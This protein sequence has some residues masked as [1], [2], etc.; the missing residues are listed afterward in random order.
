MAATADSNAQ[1]EPVS[2]WRGTIRRVLWDAIWLWLAL[3]VSSSV[4]VLKY[5]GWPGVVAYSIITAG[6]VTLVPQRFRS[7]SN[8]TAILLGVTTLVVVAIIFASTYP[9]VDVHVAGMG[10][11]DDDALNLGARAILAGQSPY[12]QRTYLGNVLH[13]LPGSYVL[14]IPFVLAGS[15]ALQ[16]LVWLPLFFIA[17]SDRKEP[18]AAVQWSW[19]VLALCPGVMWEIVTGTGYLANTIAIALGLS[20]LMRSR[21]RLLAAA[22]WGLALASRANFFLLV[23]VAIGSLAQRAGWRAAARAAAVTAATA[24]LLIVPL[25]LHDPYN[26]GPIEAADRVFRFDNVQPHAGVAI[27]ALMGALS[28]GLAFRKMDDASLF[29]SCALIQ[30]VPVAAGVLLG[31]LSQ[32]AV[33]LT[34]ARYGTFFMWFALLAAVTRRSA[35][36]DETLRGQ[37]PDEAEKVAL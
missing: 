16:N 3:T 15:S 33:D 28:V 18:A 32:G 22:A 23:P 29:R 8:R 7:F 20:W 17:G 27:I 9:R 2:R 1:S 25:Y 13:H 35:Q 10:S 26:F 14:A 30:L 31:S 19:T 24:S 12:G 5:A 34:Y 4:L 11:D 36:R 6:A 37:L 21:G